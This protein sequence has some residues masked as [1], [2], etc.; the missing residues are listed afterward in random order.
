M[1]SLSDAVAA[2]LALID[3]QAAELA[4]ARDDYA[5]IAH[6]AGIE[7]VADHCPVVPGPVEAVIG[8]IRA[9]MTSEG[10]LLES[11]ARL[12]SRVKIEENANRR[13]VLMICA[14][15]ADRDALKDDCASMSEEFGLPPT[16]R[17]VTGEIRRLRERAARTEAAEA[18]A[19][20]QAATIARLEAQLAE[21]LDAYDGGRPAG[22]PG[23]EDCD[24]PE[25]YD[26][27]W[28][29]P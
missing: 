25:T 20:A 8:A 22:L 15:E 4:T 21:R 3:A 28:R 10:N 2:A 14:A 12:E 5:R 26:D 9:A 1:P 6:A 7:Y 27:D 18:Q 24:E 11:I 16:L 29:E 17:P 13:A 23:A 19:D